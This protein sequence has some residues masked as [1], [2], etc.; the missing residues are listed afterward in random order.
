M[1]YM[2]DIS[3]LKIYKVKIFFVTVAAAANLELPHSLAILAVR[4]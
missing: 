3:L 1:F 4:H 2:S